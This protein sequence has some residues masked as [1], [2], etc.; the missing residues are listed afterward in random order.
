MPRRSKGPRLYLDPIRKVYVIRDGTRFVRTGCGER[1][2]AKAEK[3]LAQYIGQKH[4]PTP[5]SSPMIAEVL[6]AY[7][8]EVA[9]NKASA[10][11]M[12]YNI[13]NLLKWW[14]EKTV[15]DIT[16]KSCR[17]YIASKT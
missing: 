11:N 6:A 15:R 4:R 3:F 5:S 16:V 10:R 13:T 12:G 2:G 9:P 14:G 8:A 17:A 7:G 1:D